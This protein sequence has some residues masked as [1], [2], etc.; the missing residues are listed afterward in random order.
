MGPDNNQDVSST[1][2]TEK[3]MVPK[4]HADGSNWAIYAERVMNYII[5]K[6]LRRHILGTMRKPVDLVE[7]NGSFHKP[8]QL[9]PLTNEEV[10]KHEDEVDNYLMKQA[11]IR[12][13]IYRMIDM[14]MFLQVKNELDAAAGDMLSA[15]LAVAWQ[16]DRIAMDQLLTC[17]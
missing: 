2:S 13:V 1:T 4:L 12:E 8:G 16:C 10:E 11:A 15:S 6:G 14:S 9:A 5:S 17:D 7:Q 3:V